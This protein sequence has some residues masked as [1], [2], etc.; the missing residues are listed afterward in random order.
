MAVSVIGSIPNNFQLSATIYDIFKP[1]FI[2]FS[3]RKSRWDLYALQNFS[4]YDMAMPAK[5]LGKRN[6][7]TAQK[8]KEISFLKKLFKNLFRVAA[9]FTQLPN[10]LQNIFGILKY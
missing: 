5:K 6:V 10:I 8:L 2:A 4:S 1:Q 3:G 7:L 9:G